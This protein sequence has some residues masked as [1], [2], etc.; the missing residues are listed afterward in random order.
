[1]LACMI[2]LDRGC[3]SEKQQWHFRHIKHQPSPAQTDLLP[4]T[5]AHSKHVSPILPPKLH[6]RPLWLSALAV[7]QSSRRVSRRGHH[8]RCRISYHARNWLLGS[9]R[10][11]RL[12]VTAQALLL[13][14][15]TITGYDLATAA[16]NGAV[17]GA[18]LFLAMTLFE[19]VMAPLWQV[20]ESL[21]AMLIMY[22]FAY[23]GGIGLASAFGAVGSAI[24]TAAGHQVQGLGKS[25]TAGALGATPFIASHFL[26]LL[27][28]LC[29]GCR[30]EPEP[31]DRYSYPLR[32]RLSQHVQKRAGRSMSLQ[33]SE[34]VCSVVRI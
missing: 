24:L 32:L 12:E 29:C 13:I 20:A 17:G 1:M 23:A 33:P 8:Q 19:L 4:T 14:L 28:S 27:A 16:Q 7:V 25:A 3:G 30:L 21:L 31:Q 15:M 9:V 6:Q 2:C 18:I 5:R 34:Y 10:L 22:F 26:F 11:C